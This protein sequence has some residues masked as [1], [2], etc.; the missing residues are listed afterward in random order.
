MADAP[1][2]PPPTPPS[3]PSLPPT[4]YYATPLGHSFRPLPTLFHSF[5]FL[6]KSCA[7]CGQ[8]FNLIKAYDSSEGINECFTCDVYVHSMCRS[9]VETF[10]EKNRQKSTSITAEPTTTTTAANITTSTTAT[11]Q[12]PLPT[13][14]TTTTNEPTTPP[15]KP[16]PRSDLPTD[17]FTSLKSYSSALKTSMARSSIHFS[18]SPPTVEPEEMITFQSYDSDEDDDIDIFG[19]ASNSQPQPD[20]ISFTN[21]VE[22]LESIIHFSKP[23]SPPPD[24]NDP[25]KL[26]T[27]TDREFLLMRTQESVPENWAPIVESFKKEYLKLHPQPSIIS[28]LF[29][30]GSE[31][32]T[33]RSDDLDILGM[34]EEECG[35]EKEATS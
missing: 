24:P 20:N 9:R 13:T 29:N 12:Q 27:K 19:G 25:T 21:P 4:S 10:C 35:G 22:D 1:P 30:R 32:R 6:G 7:Y 26:V 3:S 18:L 2:P 33:S 8:S 34:T 28:S 16:Q 23:S 31:E 17:I 5:Y 15:S 14:T 11:P